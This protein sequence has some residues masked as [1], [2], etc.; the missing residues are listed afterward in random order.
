MD[1]N[2]TLR[3]LGP[4]ESAL[5]IAIDGGRMATMRL[6]DLGILPGVE[7]SVLANAAG[8]LLVSVGE[9]RVIVERGI[10]DKVRVI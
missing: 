6:E 1:Q 10:A 9:S 2:R 3:N 7:I 5:V 8:P 4:G